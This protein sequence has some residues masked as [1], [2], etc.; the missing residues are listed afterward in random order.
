L[1]IDNDKDLQHLLRIGKICGMALQ[2][3]LDHVEAGMTTKQLD[4]IGA[5]FL[6][7]HGARSAPILAYKF[8]GYTC[9]S[10]NDEAAHGI[11]GE[12]RIKPGDLVNVDV[13]AEL[14]GFWADCGASMIVPP[15]KPEY[16]RLCSFARR[17]LDAGIHA[18]KEGKPINAIGKAVENVARK[19]GYTIIDG[20]GGHGVGRHIHE[21]PSVPNVY[22]KSLREP[23]TAGLV[24]TIE[25]F[26]N[27]GRGQIA[28][29]K[30][31]WTL[32]TIDGSVSA[33]YEHTLV[34][35]GDTPIIVTAA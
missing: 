4:A 6:K 1:T 13:S 20:L 32:K 12:R 3:M 35:H 16:E 8:P 2:H 24:F 9:I 30:D 10:L 29:A 23:L 7:Q 27:T 33:Q 22:V 5:A 26:L 34:I 31:G 15:V 14:E 19:G 18:A 25:P 17:A 11:P 28:T 21:K